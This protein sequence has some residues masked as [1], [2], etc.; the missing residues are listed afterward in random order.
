MVIEWLRFRMRPEQRQAFIERD[1]QVW[2]AGL[3]AWPGF[4]DKEIWL[5]P[6]QDT[7]VIAVI[8]WQT[9]EQWKAVPA[10]VITDLDQR[11]GDL[12]FPIV[13]SREYQVRK[14]VP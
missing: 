11:M 14:F 3:Q 12:R 13:E 4:L 10:A 8:R 7:D 1:A 2:T 6:S 9:R 5:D